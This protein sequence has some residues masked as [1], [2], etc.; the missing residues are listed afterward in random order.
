V[1]GGSADP[2]SDG[3]IDVN[4]GRVPSL[5]VLIG[6]VGHSPERIERTGVHVAGFNANDGRPVQFGKHKLEGIRV[7]A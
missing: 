7:D 1:L 2:Q 3:S 6:R 5:P 4:P